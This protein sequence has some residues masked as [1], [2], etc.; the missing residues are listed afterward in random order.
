MSVAEVEPLDDALVND[1]QLLT[2]NVRSALQLGQ[3]RPELLFPLV[4]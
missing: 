3:E 4:H 2:L 1:A